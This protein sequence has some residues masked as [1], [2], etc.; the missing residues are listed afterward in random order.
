MKKLKKIPNTLI[1][2]EMNL[3]ANKMGSD[4]APSIVKNNYSECFKQMEI[5]K[6]KEDRNFS[7]WTQIQKYNFKNL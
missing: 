7:Q 4:F 1:G 2:V 3:G 6:L 5:L